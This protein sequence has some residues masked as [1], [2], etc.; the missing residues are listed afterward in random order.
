MKIILS[1]SVFLFFIIAKANSQNRT[2]IWELGVRTFNGFPKCGIDFN[3]GT[4]IPFTEVRD[5]PFLVTN[6]S[7]CDTAGQML[8]YTNGIYV[9]NKNHDTLQNGSSFNPG[10]LTS[11]NQ[12]DGLS[13]VQGAII[14]PFPEHFDKYIII[15]ESAEE[16]I[17]DSILQDQ[18]MFLAYSLVDM[19][20]DNGNGGI[21]SSFKTIH[22]VDDTMA[23]GRITACKH[24]NGRDWWIVAPRFYSN[25]YYK[26]LLSPTGFDTTIVQ[27]IGSPIL[28][29]ALG[30]AKFSPD[31]SSY[32]I[33]DWA[34]NLNIFKFDR[35]SGEF[36]DT[37]FIPIPN[38]TPGQPDNEAITCEFSPNSRFLYV[39]LY[40]RIIQFDLWATDIVSSLTYVADWDTFAA[41][42]NTYFF[43]SQ[44]ASDQRIYISTYGGDSVMH[45][46]EL[47]DSQGTFCNVIQNSFFF[48][49][50]NGSI[51]NFPNYELGSLV[52]SVC[53][54]IYTG[55]IE[56]NS[57]NFKIYPN[58]VSSRINI[59]VS[60][61]GASSGH[62]KI[63]NSLGEIVY[64]KLSP[65]KQSL[66]VSF[67]KTGLYLL[68]FETN[69]NVYFK[70]IIKE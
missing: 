58:P 44:L 52:G 20:M 67:L 37:S 47:P 25:L 69:S 18:P 48:Q 33:L 53:D 28:Y 23:V 3:T 13:L 56:P 49:S 66:D 14:L 2:Q 63:L 65:L 9:A 36:Y 30:C 8:F 43:L 7:M 5:M 4:A 42:F 45:Y 31:G 68:L 40:T 55:V 29:D 16:F 64:W 34:N 6:A 22:L 11:T 17:Y 35:C 38:P 60:E 27:Q 54:T 1:L 62:L 59:S 57:E 19:N 50:Y 39:V 21:D 32:A 12:G 41:P 26:L 46:I 51:P 24:A 10:Y 15:H 61:S 70:K